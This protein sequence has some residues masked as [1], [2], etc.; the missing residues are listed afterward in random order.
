M[1]GILEL[2][3]G[4]TTCASEPGKFCEFAGTKRFGTLPV[5]ALFDQRLFD[6]DDGWLARCPKCLAQWPSKIRASTPVGVR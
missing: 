5:C 2:E 6:N 1:K 4:D 3:F